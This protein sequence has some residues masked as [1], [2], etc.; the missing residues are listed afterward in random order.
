L[1]KQAEKRNL[2]TKDDACVLDDLNI[3]QQVS[4]VGGK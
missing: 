2:A 4:I 3:G 1:S